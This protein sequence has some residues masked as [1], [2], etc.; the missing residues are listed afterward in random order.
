[1]EVL[2]A[3]IADAD[4]ISWSQVQFDGAVGYSASDYLSAVEVATSEPAVESASSV[5]A[6]TAGDEASVEG[7]DGLG[8]SVRASPEIDAP[9]LTGISEGASIRVVDGPSVDESGETWYQVD[10]DGIVGWVR[11]AYLTAITR[12]VM[13]AVYNPGAD[14]VSA[15]QQYLE[16]PYLWGG[17][18][19][20]GF[21][22]SGFVYYIVNQVFA[23]DYPREM[24][25][26][27]L[28]GSYVPIDALQPGD[29]VFFEN[30]YKPGLSH[31]GFYLGDGQF[32]SA[33]GR[34]DEVGIQDMSDP[35][36][37]SRYVTARRI[38]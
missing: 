28:T 31:V 19:P 9:S 5:P 2:A 3:G 33:T 38:V 6:L 12:E 35:Y 4:G 29:L 1:M 30:T 7:T 26:Q 15:A 8:L 32:I 27:V 21:D 13:A 18:T 20:E 17:S 37:S 16:T 24:E 14:L 23:S 34:L 25:Q 36:W 10:A 11:G 22:C